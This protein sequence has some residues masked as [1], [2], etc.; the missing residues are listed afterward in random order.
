VQQPV[1][2]GLLG[3]NFGLTVCRELTGNPSLPVKLVKVCDLDE[4]RAKAAAAEFNVPST[5]SLDELLDDPDIDAVGLWCGPDH[6]ADLVRRVIRAGKDVMTTK[7]FELDPEAALAV[8]HEAKALGR[9][10]HMNSPNPRPFG[11]EAILHEWIDSG[12]IGRPTIAHV[13][14]WCYY[15][16]TPADGTW[17]DDPLR[18][19]VAPVFRLGIYPLN[20]LI[21]ILGEAESVQVMH[22]RIETGR[23]TPDNAT[24]TVLFKNGAIATIL[25]SFVV[26]SRPD[27]Y[28]GST[29]IGGT[30]GIVWVNPGP[31]SRD[32]RPQSNVMLSTNDRLEFRSVTRFAGDYDWEFFAQRVRGEIESDVTTPERIASAIRVVRAMSEA[33]RTG[34]TVKVR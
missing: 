29:T 6:R 34:N 22:S 3:L 18:C 28:R 11:Q 25:S 14:T 4:Q 26:G 7:P 16:A 12:A 20:T 10:V 33:E 9:V 8:L 1:R 5:Q 32:G 21:G 24:L 19:P 23:P 27:C 17:Y 2:L 30:K 15:G 31:A 13:D